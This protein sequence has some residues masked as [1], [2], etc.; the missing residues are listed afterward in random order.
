MRTL[1][2]AIWRNPTAVIDITLTLIMAASIVQSA[3]T[4]KSEYALSYLRWT[5][6]P[7]CAYKTFSALRDMNLFLE[8]YLIM[9]IVWCFLYLLILPSRGAYPSSEAWVALNTSVDG[10]LQPGI[11]FA[12]PCFP[13]ASNET[14]GHFSPS[15][16]NIVEADYLNHRSSDL[17][18]DCPSSNLTGL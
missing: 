3:S 13:L 14:K 9:L 17:V 2:Y 6:T 8:L 7:W 16:C 18:L 11:P 1:G 10:R 12:R 5:V 4:I 15:D